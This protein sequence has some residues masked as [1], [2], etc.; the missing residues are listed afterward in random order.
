[1]TASLVG[2]VAFAGVACGGDDADQAST[3][4]TADDTP[5]VRITSPADGTTTK[6][7]VVSLDLEVNGIRVVKADGDTSGETG[8]IHAFIDRG[9]VAPGVAIPR[10]A[11][12]VHSADNPVVLTGLSVGAHTIAVVIGDGA[13]NRIGSAE[14]EIKVTVE[15]PSVDA[16]APA[17][18]AAGSPVRIDFKA[19]GVQIRAADGDTSGATGHYHVFVDKPLPKL[20]E[21]IPRPDDGS[22]IH[23]TESFVELRNLAAGEHNIFVV[24]GDGAHMPLNPLVADKV[25][26]TVA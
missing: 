10:E 15:G 20:G 9:P 23:T 3:T 26:V 22:I 1:M 19:A 14:D 13:H 24:V 17:T 21:V 12:I 8:H 7:N 18:A 2:A 6:G 11:G 16:T 4:T 5:S 25:T